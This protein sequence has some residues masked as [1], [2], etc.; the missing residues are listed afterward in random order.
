MPFA[1]KVRYA[2]FFS[3]LLVLV[4]IYVTT[5]PASTRNSAFYQK[6]V[7]LMDYRAGRG[8]DP[9]ENKIPDRPIHRAGGLHFAEGE[10]HLTPQERA[11]MEHG[12]LKGEPAIGPDGQPIGLDGEP[13][14]AEELEIGPV[15]QSHQRGQRPLIDTDAKLRERLNQAERAAKKSADEKYRA[16]KDIEDEVRKEREQR[17]DDV[18]API[19]S[20]KKEALDRMR[21]KLK[22]NK[23]KVQDEGEDND[24][25]T[26]D[27]QPNSKDASSD[28]QAEKSIAGRK[29]VPAESQNSQ[30][31]QEKDVPSSKDPSN[32]EPNPAFA[33]SDPKKKSIQDKDQHK[34]TGEDD[35]AHH[36]RTLLAEILAKSPVT[37]FSKSHCPFSMKAKRILLE[38]YAIKPAPF[39]VELNEHPDGPALQKLLQ[40][41]TG[42]KTV[43]NVLVNGKSIGGGDETELLWRNGEL[44]ARIQQM[45][46][47][48]VESVG[49]V[50]AFGQKPPEQGAQQK[51]V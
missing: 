7:A 47:K 49:V 24:S 30:D 11:A 14:S 45:A 48:R 6:T 34:D 21:E 32:A 46:G 10:H 12:K 39:V 9:N 41:T 5:G 27:R 20:T 3:I 42:R 25:D 23:D 50:Y 38:A 31:S 43:P 13:I 17:G 33:T 16:L 19:H 37:I 36:T 29:K 44:P 51:P 35:E 4:I 40:K 15:D 2:L 8:P 26:S 18:N 22:S 28:A 1:L